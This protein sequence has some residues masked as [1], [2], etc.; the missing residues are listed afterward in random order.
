MMSVSHWGMHQV[1]EKIIQGYFRNG[2][3]EY[4]KSVVVA[5]NTDAQDWRSLPLD[6]YD[7]KYLHG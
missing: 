3:R 4:V 2:Y 7:A 5:W 6:Q 1:P